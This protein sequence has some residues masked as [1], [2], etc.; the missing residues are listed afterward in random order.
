VLEFDGLDHIAGLA[1][2]ELVAPKLLAE[3]AAAG[4]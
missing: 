4:W 1:S 2:A 3:L